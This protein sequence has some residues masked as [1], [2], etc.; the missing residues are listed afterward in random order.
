LQRL[1]VAKAIKVENV[2][3]VLPTDPT[4]IVDGYGAFPIINHKAVHLKLLNPDVVGVYGN[5]LGSPNIGWQDQP[6]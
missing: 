2:K 4:E 6:A 3:G 5:V 1:G